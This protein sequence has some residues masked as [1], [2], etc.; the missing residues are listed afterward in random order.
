[1]SHIEIVFLALALSIDACVVSFSYGL[2]FKENFN[3][4]SIL[5]ASFTGFF[6]GLMP[7]LG[8]FLTSIVKSYIEPY[9]KWIIFCIFVYLCKIFW[10]SGSVICTCNCCYGFGFNRRI[11]Y[12]KY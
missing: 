7:L 1:M 12:E 4:N 9:A 8:Y 11:V 6:Q 5:L 2:A 10:Y 3:K